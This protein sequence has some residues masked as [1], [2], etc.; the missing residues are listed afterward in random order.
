M[1]WRPCSSNHL[2]PCM[3]HVES[4][5]NGSP[6][7][8]L[9]KVAVGDVLAS[10]NMFVCS[11]FSSERNGGS[12]WYTCPLVC[13]FQPK[14]LLSLDT[15]CFLYEASCVMT[16]ATDEQSPLPWPSQHCALQF[17]SHFLK[18]HLIC[19]QSTNEADYNNY[20]FCIS[21]ALF[22]C[23]KTFHCQQPEEDLNCPQH[24]GQALYFK[25]F[26]ETL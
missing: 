5:G 12:G 10:W 6:R 22:V 26:K 14:C 8:K 16:S 19:L 20:W 13:M 2:R 4:F 15:T 23:M 7:H 18:H 24:P 21:W 17:T 11:S 3:M 25:Y 1:W 9:A